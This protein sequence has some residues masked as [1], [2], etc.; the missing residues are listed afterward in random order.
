MF[1]NLLSDKGRHYVGIQNDGELLDWTSPTHPPQ[2][3]Q[4]MYLKLAL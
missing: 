1:K 2:L 4:C 3:F